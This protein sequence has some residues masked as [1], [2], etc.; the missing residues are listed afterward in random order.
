MDEDGGMKQRCSLSD[1]MEPL[2]GS[3]LTT[4]M[5]AVRDTLKD[6]ACPKRLQP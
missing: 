5:G 4:E 3:V 6:I 1:F 2:P